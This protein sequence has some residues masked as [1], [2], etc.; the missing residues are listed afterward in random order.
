MQD[1]VEVIYRDGM[2]KK[3]TYIYEPYTILKIKIDNKVETLDNVLCKASKIKFKLNNKKYIYSNPKRIVIN[4]NRLNKQD[5]LSLD[6]DILADLLDISRQMGHKELEKI[7]V[8][9]T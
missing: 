2:I 4:M 5:I 6:K 3:G 9:Q 1:E 7:I 8:H